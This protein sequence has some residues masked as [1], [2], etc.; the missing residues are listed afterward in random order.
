M[1]KTK[2]TT[3]PVSNT[4]ISS[5]D[6]F[7]KAGNK[8][9]FLALGLLILVAF[10]VFKD[11]ILLKKLYLFQDIGS[12]TV[13]GAWPFFYNFANYFNKDG[14]PTWSFQEGMGQNV[15]GGFLRDP[16][17]MI[18]YLAGP[19]SMPKIYVFIEL[20]K[21]IS[22]GVVFYLFLKTLKISNFTA[23]IGCLL[24][25]FSGFMIIG[26]CWYVFTYEAFTLALALLGFELFL[27]KNK[28]IVFV[29]AIAL[30]G[31]SMPFN[32]YVVGLILIFYILFRLGQ[33]G[34]FKLNSFIQLLLKLAAFGIVGLLISAPFLFESA[35]QLVESPRGS[36]TSSYFDILSSKPM[37]AIIDKLQFGTFITRLFSSDYIGSGSDFRGWQNFLEAPVSYCGI[38]S[39]VLMPQIF[40]SVSKTAR[41]WYIIWLMIW[42]VPSLF[43][44]FRYAFWLFSGDY[45]RI[46]SFCL[47]LV[48][49]MYSVFA[50]DIILKT[51]K[52]NLITLVITVVL[53]IVLLSYNYFKGTNTQ[54]DS[55]ISIFV[56][57]MLVI[58]AGL[59]FLI[60]KKADNSALKYALIALVCFELAFLS[61]YSVNRRDAIQTRE[62]SEKIAYND[63][64]VEAVNYIKTKETGFYRIDKNY[65]SS[66]AIHGSLNDNKIHNYYGTS[67][68]SSFANNNYINYLREYGVIS[69][70]NEY[71]SRWAPGLINRPIL[72]SLNNVKYIMAKGYSNPVWRATHD[73][74][75]KFGDVLV[76]KSKYSLPFGY[77][78]D[79]YIRQ[80]DFDK[81]SLNQKDFVSLQACVLK[82]EEAAAV[83][84]LKI[85]NV[86]DTVLNSQFSFE[87]YKAEITKRSAEAMKLSSFT[88]KRFNGEI[89]TEKPGI[90]YLSFPFDKGWHLK[91]DGTDSKLLSVSNGMTGVYLQKGEHKI[92][93]VYKLRVFNK[94]LLLIPIGILLMLAIMLL[95]KKNVNLLK[96]N[97]TTN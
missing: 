86:A 20:L 16:F 52:I 11:F 4:A 31:I 67:S 88:D 50:L 94:G 40:T 91:L 34:Q 97:Y 24:F 73:S 41:K 70:A 17:M 62:L 19:S 27:Q 65:Y 81:L 49:I 66:G 28:W 56:K 63:Y 30:I 85:Y 42:L 92:E 6:F 78:Y 3:S 72:Q 22:T 51:R 93:M 89:K 71:E 44:Y 87:S 36:G 64:S 13:N 75:A 74:V 47:S 60:T 53:C 77:T 33:T 80:S 83:K 61:S 54:I 9:V 37:F 82:D 5:I 2:T 12:D 7:E 29:I 95:N 38:L 35:L 23:T 32:L 10:F 57:A 43:P 25:A 15:V 76:L 79:Q 26:S 84:G 46:F 55:T 96:S 90:M 69:K 58:Y 39:I 48:F 1:N 21:I 8:G 18:G 14:L 45:Y 68:Y 59:L